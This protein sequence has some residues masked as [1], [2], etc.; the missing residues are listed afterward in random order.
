MTLPTHA[1][2]RAAYLDIVTD[3]NYSSAQIVPYLRDSVESSARSL[4]DDETH[5][6]GV[7]RLKLSAARSNFNFL[8]I[9]MLLKIT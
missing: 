3:A 5:D 7:R 2:L 8:P 1:I 9:P 4:V 6:G